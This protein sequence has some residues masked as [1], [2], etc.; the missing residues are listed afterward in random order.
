MYLSRDDMVALCSLSELIQ[1]S[2]DEMGSHYDYQAT[3]PDWVLIDRAIEYA[4]QVA[5]GYLSGRYALP[6]KQTPTLLMHWC[7]DIAR[8]HLHKRRI[9]A[10]ELPKPL[11]ASYDD[12]IKLLGQVRDGKL[13][14]G[15]V[16][17]QHTK[18]HDERGAYQ[19]RSRGK[20]D[21]SGY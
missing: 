5:D 19:V 13:H 20:A 14:L 8:Y 11:Q 1:L 17:D 6:L 4:C 16:D 2:K 9:N 15:V 12:A 18:L 3:E 21:W 7:A 10:S